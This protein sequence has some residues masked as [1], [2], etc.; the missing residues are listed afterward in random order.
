MTFLKY[1]GYSVY[2]IAFVAA[3]IIFSIGDAIQNRRPEVLAFFLT[4]CFTFMASVLHQYPFSER[5]ILFLGPFIYLLIIRGLQILAEQKAPLIPLILTIFLLVPSLSS[6]YRLW[7]MPI[8]REE[9]R[10]IL[11]YLDNHQMPNDRVYI[12]HG[13]RPAAEYYQR[14]RGFSLHNVYWGV[15][16]TL[17]RSQYLKDIKYM[18]QWPRVWF[19]FTRQVKDEEI[20]FRSNIDGEA[21][22]QYH[23][24]GTS[25]YLYYFG[26][27]GSDKQSDHTH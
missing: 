24:P 16:W 18:E 23:M 20:F 19:L 27:S 12:Y 25:L 7:T 5:L 26:D 17:D 21:L 1:L 4:I 22:D 14:Y 3:L 13:A 8:V 11:R 2:W 9:I 6:A 15:P 10:P